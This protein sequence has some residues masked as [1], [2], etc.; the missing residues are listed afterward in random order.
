MKMRWRVIVE[1][2]SNENAEELADRWHIL[3]P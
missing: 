2:H 1:E 3:T